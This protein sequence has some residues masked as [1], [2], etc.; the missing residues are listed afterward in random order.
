MTM[1]EK[2]SRS[3]PLGL[4]RELVRTTTESM[5]TPQHARSE[6]RESPGP[7]KEVEKKRLEVERSRDELTRFGDALAE[8]FGFPRESECFF[9]HLALQLEL[10]ALLGVLE[11]ESGAAFL[12]ALVRSIDRV[13]ARWAGRTRC[14]ECSTE[15]TGRLGTSSAHTKK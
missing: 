10:E 7:L 14:P 13:E 3:D 15:V 8:T 4:L 9:S 12:E 5:G 1:P 6:Q 11:G 2:S